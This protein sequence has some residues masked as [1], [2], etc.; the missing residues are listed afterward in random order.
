MKLNERHVFAALDAVRGKWKPLIIQRLTG[1][2]RRFGELRREVV[3][4]TKK[5]LT[6]QLRELERDTLVSRTSRT[7]PLRVDYRLTA[8]GEWYG[9][10][11]EQMNHWLEQQSRVPEKSAPTE[12][13]A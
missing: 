3:G 4:V 10:L 13:C 11:F 7:Q 1:G 6:Q 9:L 12:E 5:V 2:P 8:R